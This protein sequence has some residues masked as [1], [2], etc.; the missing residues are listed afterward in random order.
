MSLIRLLVFAL[1]VRWARLGF[2]DEIL[3]AGSSLLGPLF[4]NGFAE[5]AAHAQRHF[6]SREALLNRDFQERMS[7]TAYQRAVSDMKAAGLNP[8]LAYSQGPASTPSGATGAPVAQH[9]P[10]VDIGPQQFVAAAQVQRVD[11]ETDALKAEAERRRAETDEIRQRTPTHGVTRDHLRQQITESIERV[12]EIA[13]NTRYLF[14]QTQTSA[15]NEAKQQQEIRNLREQVPQIQATVRMLQQQAK[16]L[17]AHASQLSTQE[18]Y[19]QAQIDA[20]LPA[21]EAAIKKVEEHLMRLELP[22]AGMDAAAHSSFAGAVGALF[23][24]LNPFST[25]FTNLNRR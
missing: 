16:Y 6:S 11:A 5:E 25:L 8:M 23:R 1:G 10:K 17:S 15:V 4:E 9:V 24:A 14:Q 12:G 19:T 18:K 7:N 13:A 21:L 22:K 20:N 2:I 3:G